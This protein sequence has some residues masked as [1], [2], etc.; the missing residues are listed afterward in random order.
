MT[1]AEKLAYRQHIDEIH[2][3]NRVILATGICPKCGH[4]LLRNLALTGW[5]QCEQL[6]AP[7]FRYDSSKPS[8]DTQF[9]V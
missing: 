6:G 7:S 4:A 8:C 9:F 5:I 3:K 2:A 1:K